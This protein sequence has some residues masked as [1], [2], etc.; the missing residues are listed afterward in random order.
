MFR[1]GCLWRGRLMTETGRPFVPRPDEQVD[2]IASSSAS[3]SDNRNRGHSNLTSSWLDSPLHLTRQ[4]GTPQD[5]SRVL[6][7][8]AWCG[9]AQ[10]WICSDLTPFLNDQ[11]YA[12]VRPQSVPGRL[13]DRSLVVAFSCPSEF[14]SSRVA[15]CPS[16]V[17]PGPYPV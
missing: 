4:A 17:S 2:V 1:R 7:S 3:T 14:P 5:A 10:P 16:L 8:L 9:N 11:R 15:R 13:Q 12:R 6:F